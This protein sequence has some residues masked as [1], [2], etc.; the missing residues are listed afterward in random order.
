MG[1][2]PHFPNIFYGF[3]TPGP[4]PRPSPG[5]G[6]QFPVKNAGFGCVF[7]ELRPFSMFLNSFVCVLRVFGTVLSVLKVFCAFWEC[8]V[9]FGHVLHV[10]E[11]FCLCFACLGTVLRVLEA[12]LS[13]RDQVGC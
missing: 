10:I 12:K 11:C 4:C 3:G 5:L 1:Q 6:V 8:F 7:A 13:S 9:R 2:K